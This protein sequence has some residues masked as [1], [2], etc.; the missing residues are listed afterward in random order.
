MAK[1]VLVANS[2]WYFLNFRQA[3]LKDL[4]KRGYQVILVAPEDEY[5]ARLRAEGFTLVTVPLRRKSL[6][7]WD[8]F[9]FLTALV[10]VYRRERP[11][12]VHHYTVKCAL[13]GTLAARLTGVP[14][15]LNSVTG[16]GH[17]FLSRHW[18]MRL[19]RALY[20]PLYRAIGARAAFLFQNPDDLALFR[21]LGFRGRLCLVRGSGVNTERFA[22]NPLPRN[23]GQAP[24]ILFVGRMLKEKGVYELAEAARRLREE[25]LSF[26]LLCAG[27][28]DQGNP[29]AVSEAELRAWERE[30]CLRWL[31]HVDDI[32]TLLRCAQIAVL[33]SWREGL[34]KSLLEAGA[35]GLALVATDVPGCREIVE[36][37]VSGLLVAPRDPAALAAALRRMLAEPSLRTRLGAAAVEKV[38]REFSQ[39]RVHE[40]TA[41]IYRELLNQS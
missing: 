27:G 35:A 22:P 40:A 13:Y 15:V 9:R 28:I 32:P 29:S 14:A 18:T 20:L 36:D 12:L 39:E 26:H 25:G 23:D 19:V 4:R 37:E 38:R 8:D 17:L 16:L 33:P 41:E 2:S 30:G 10:R 7:G 3:F 31:G 34:P 21:S 1:V 24:T 5:H 11:D 6:N